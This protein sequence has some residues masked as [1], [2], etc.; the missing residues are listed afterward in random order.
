MI[1]MAVAITTK[2]T[3]KLAAVVPHR[4]EAAAITRPVVL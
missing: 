2:A 1:T 4:E 3:I